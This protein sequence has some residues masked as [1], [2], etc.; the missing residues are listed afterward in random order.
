MFELSCTPLDEAAASKHVR[1]PSAGATCVFVGTTRN[2]FG[3]KTVMQLEY[4]AYTSMALKTLQVIAL[5][6][7]QGKLVRPE[8]APQLR[9]HGSDTAVSAE[10]DKILSIYISHR[11]GVVPVGEASVVIAVA[12]GHRRAAFAATEA[13][14]E[15]LK[16]SVPIWKREFYASREDEDAK[17]VYEDALPGH[18]LASPPAWKANFA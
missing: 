16:R 3:G 10:D 15:E 12:S 11:L 9:G 7:R 14:L 13:I 18:S 4:E 2:S 17:T 8:G 1:H 6:A 5:R